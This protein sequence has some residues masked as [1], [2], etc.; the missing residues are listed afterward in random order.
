MAAAG[1]RARTRVGPVSTAKEHA[2]QA[3][4]K[5]VGARWIR[6]NAALKGKIVIVASVQRAVIDSVLADVA[7]IHRAKRAAMHRKWLIYQGPTSRAH[8]VQRA[9]TRLA[10]R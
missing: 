10:S 5:R 9:C 8:T 4:H 7:Q 2:G 1:Q 3:D 6:T